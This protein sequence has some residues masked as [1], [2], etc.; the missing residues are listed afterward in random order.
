MALFIIPFLGYVNRF[1][2]SILISF[3]ICRHCHIIYIK[4]NVNFNINVN[5]N[6]N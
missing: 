2:A 5:V 4:V 6:L 3:V 1:F